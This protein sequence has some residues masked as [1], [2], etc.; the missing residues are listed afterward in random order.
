MRERAVTDDDVH[1]TL[2]N[3]IHSKEIVTD[4]LG[5]KSQI[6]IGKN[7]TVCVDP[8]TGNVITAWKTGTKTKKKYTGGD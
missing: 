7:A 8:D 6:L 5:R 3:P 1:D 2:T 4:H